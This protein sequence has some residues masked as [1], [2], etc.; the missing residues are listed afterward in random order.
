M[1]PLAT[2][3]GSVWLERSVRDA[4]AARSNRA[5]PTIKKQTGSSE[6][7]A[8]FLF[9]KS[10]MCSL[11]CGACDAGGRRGLASKRHSCRPA[12]AVCGSGCRGDPRGG[13]AGTLLPSIAAPFFAGHIRC[14][15]LRCCSLPGGSECGERDCLAPSAIPEAGRQAAA[16]AQ[17]MIF[18]AKVFDRTGRLLYIAFH[19]AL[20]AQ[21]DR[22]TGYEP[23]GQE[24]ESLRAHHAN[25]GDQFYWPPF[26]LCT[27]LL[28]V[29][30]ISVSALSQRDMREG[31]FGPPAG[32]LF[33]PRALCYKAGSG[34]GLPFRTGP[35]FGPA[36]RNVPMHISRRKTARGKQGTGSPG[37]CRQA[38]APW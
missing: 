3:C 30:C 34:A 6:A 32:H 9:P 4:E 24:F 13:A 37:Q 16:F 25:S 11:L 1:S 29:A 35:A 15:G 10:G 22:A 21:L 14:P 36:P 31:A 17:K 23:V 27:G 38:P 12:Y 28:P 5:I 2:G 7:G 19:N 33:R 20:V 18:C 8:R 26:L